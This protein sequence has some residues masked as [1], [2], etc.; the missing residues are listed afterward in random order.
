MPAGAPIGSGLGIQ[1]LTNLRIIKEQTRVP[2]I[3][4]A[5]VGTASDAAIAMELGADAVLLNTAVA[6]ARDP[7]AMA[8]AMKHAVI[9]GRLAWLRRPHPEA[10]LR[11]GQQPDRRHGGPLGG[12]GG[13]AHGL[14][15]RP[16]PPEARPRGRR[17]ALQRRPH[18]GRP[19]RPA[20]SA[21]CRIRRPAPTNTRSRRSTSAGNC[22]ATRPAGGGWRGRLAAFVWRTMQPA[23]AAQQRFN[24]TLVDHVN[25]SVPRERAVTDAIAATIG[26]VRRQIEEAAHFQSMLV[27]YLQTLTPYVDTKDYE[28]AGLARRTAEDA[29][30]AIGRLDDISRG[31]AAALSGLSDE[32]LKRYESLLGRDQRY[33]ARLADLATAVTILQQTSLA[34]SREIARGLPAAAPAQRPRPGSSARRRQPRH[35]PDRRALS[36][37]WPAIACRA[38]STPASRISSAAAK[39]RSASAWPTTC[40]SSPAPA[41]SWTS[42]A[43]V[44]S[45]WTCCAAPASAR[46]AWI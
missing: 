46:A 31:L 17:R 16:R 44:A 20:R 33:D 22:W 34:L 37:C 6:G 29:Q 2:V 38:S 14:G 4:D 36:R 27:V 45:S 12:R 39:A 8:A 24:S 10:A 35:R 40:R 9:A 21:S 1:N 32:M 28:F 11:H 15:G 30:V 23:L 7:V 25:R 3:V 13:R 19:G 41:T 42:A 5:G 26:L 43:A 18:R